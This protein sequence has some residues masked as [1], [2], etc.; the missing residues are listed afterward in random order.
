MRIATENLHWPN[1]DA[2]KRHDIRRVT[3][4]AGLIFFQ[5]TYRTPIGQIL[6]NKWETLDSDQTGKRDIAVAWRKDNHH[7]LKK[8]FHIIGHMEKGSKKTFAIAWVEFENFIVGSVH[9]PHGAYEKE[10]PGIQEECAKGVATWVNAQLKPVLLGGD[11]N[12]DIHNDPY[13]LARRTGL[14]WHGGGSRNIDGFLADKRFDFS[15]MRS[16][17]AGIY[18]DHPVVFA[19]ARLRRKRRRLLDRLRGK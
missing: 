9:P 4:N 18:S 7:A 5:E 16:L 6:G 12:K 3:P 10:D 17:D 19:T 14:V 15:N 8:G 11:W 1:T 13:G 2:E